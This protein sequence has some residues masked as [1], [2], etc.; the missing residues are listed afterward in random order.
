LWTMMRCLKARII[1]L[2][3]TGNITD[4]EKLQKLNHLLMTKNWNLYCIHHS[5][6]TSDRDYL[7]DYA[8][9]KKARRGMN[10]IQIHKTRMGD[11]LKRKMCAH[12][13]REFHPFLYPAP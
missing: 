12:H 7:P 13:Y 1:C 8:L 5:A 2:S 10:S 3:G 6:I 11:E 9:K 4:I